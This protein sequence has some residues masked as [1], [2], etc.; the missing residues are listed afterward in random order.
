L[1]SARLADRLAGP[2]VSDTPAREVSRPML[3]VEPT[4]EST[5]T[6]LANGATADTRLAP[7]PEERRLSHEL[8][9]SEAEEQPW[10]GNGSGGGGTRRLVVILILVIILAGIAAVV[11]RTE[12]IAA[13]P[14][15]KSVYAQ[16]GL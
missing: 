4:A 10:A 8:D 16:F 1:A 15:L 5:R 14:S 6:L 13:V 2:L 12:I 7:D 9:F 3:A 11:L